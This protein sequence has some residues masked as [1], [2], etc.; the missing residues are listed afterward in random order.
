MKKVEK[1]RKRGT[2]HYKI[3][4]RFKNSNKKFAASKSSGKLFCIELN[5]FFGG[6]MI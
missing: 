5:L 4:K 3:T 2:G 6:G 1:R